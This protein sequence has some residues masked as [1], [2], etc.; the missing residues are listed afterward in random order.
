MKQQTNVRLRD[1][2][3]EVLM[4]IGRNIVLY[5]QVEH[6]LKVVIPYGNYSG[7]VHE[8]DNILTKQ[9]ACTKKQ[10]MGNLVRQYIENTHPAQVGPSTPDNIN[11]PYV[12]FNMRFNDDTLSHDKRKEA[13]AN[14]VSERNNL[15]HHLLPRFNTGSFD[16]CEELAQELDKQSEKIRS[17]I[18][19]LRSMAENINQ[20]RIRTINFLT[21]PNVDEKFKL[22]RL[23]QSQ[24]ILLLRDCINASHRA[25]GWTSMSLAGQYLSQQAPKEYSLMN[26]IYGCKSLKAF[27]DKAGIFEVYEE[28]TLRGGIRLLYKLKP[29]G[30]SYYEELTPSI[31]P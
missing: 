7:Y 9:K 18:E 12:S 4:K 23:R 30:I 14:M 22:M 2:V 8:L 11:D 17:Q 19:S 24:L 27:I 3:D 21:S 13:L 10:T 1:L 20:V 26:N 5:Q 25:D 16:S 29:D 31:T 28:P 6:I 15:I